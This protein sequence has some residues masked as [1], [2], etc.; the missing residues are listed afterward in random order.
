MDTVTLDEL[1][2]SC[3]AMDHIE[4]IE[5]ISGAAQGEM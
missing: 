2:G 1:V 4:D 3:N 5:D